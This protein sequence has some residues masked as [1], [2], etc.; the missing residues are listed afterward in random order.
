M[1]IDTPRPFSDLLDDLKPLA[2]LITQLTAELCTRIGPDM[3]A[4]FAEHA[5]AHPPKVDDVPDLLELINARVRV[6]R[7]LDQ[8]PTIPGVH[9][10][11]GRVWLLV[12]VNLLDVMA[13]C[14]PDATGP[15]MTR[16]LRDLACAIWIGARAEQVLIVLGGPSLK[17][18][19]LRLG[20]EGGW[21]S[22]KQI[23]DGLKTL[24]VPSLDDLGVTWETLQRK[25]PPTIDL[26]RIFD[27]ARGFYG[28]R[29]QLLD[30]LRDAARRERP[31]PRWE[32]TRCWHQWQGHGKG[33][34]CPQCGATG[35][36]DVIRP[37]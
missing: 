9:P 25:I 35:E 6:E 16:R 18:V 10:D 7:D 11:L 3:Q 26:G 20:I 34:T 19:H 5:E 15:E 2:P 28:I 4:R 29:R 1:P 33:K 37:M 23:E 32:C 30:D 22:P 27:P 14:E 21:L 17:A 12:G 8:L 36:E 24:G 31:S 13:T